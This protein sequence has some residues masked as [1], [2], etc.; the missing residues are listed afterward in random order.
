MLKQTTSRHLKAI[1]GQNCKASD[2]LATHQQV[3]VLG[4]HHVS[5]DVKSVPA[6]DP[7]EIVNE[8]VS[9]TRRRQKLRAMVAGKSDVMQ[10]A[11]LLITLQSPR[12]GVRLEASWL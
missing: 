8:E 1:S 5:Y 2:K 7:L 12:H 4:H 10:L 11:S 6:T 3:H 9:G